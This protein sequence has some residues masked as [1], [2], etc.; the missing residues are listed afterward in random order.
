MAPGNSLA[1]LQQALGH[2][3]AN[4]TLLRQAV[5]HASAAGGAGAASLERL[6]FLGDRVLGLALA[7]MLLREFPAE[8]P[9]D[10]ARRHAALASGEALA[11]VGRSIGLHRHLEIQPG[12]ARDREALPISVIEDACEAVIGAVYLDAGHDAACA[13]I[14]RFW[15]PMLPGAPPRDAKTALQEWAQARG[16]PLPAYRMADRE[17]PDHVPV[18]TVEARIEGFP[19]VEASAGSKRA[20]ERAAARL[21]LDLVDDSRR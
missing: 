12:M 20:A 2:G 4:P 11:S 15:G 8:A 18:F 10:L 21:L 5:T 1:E 6:E 3:F 14:E 17:G 19:E 7:T 16:L 13:V 9:G